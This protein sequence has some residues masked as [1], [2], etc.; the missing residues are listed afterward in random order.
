MRRP[1]ALALAGLA[2]LSVLLLAGCP[3]SRPDVPEATVRKEAGRD[4]IRQ[5]EAL[6]GA[7]VTAVIQSSLVG[8][9]NNIGAEAELPA[10][11]STAQLN[12]VGDSIERTIWLSDLDPLGRININ[13]TREGSSVRV[14]QRLY[15]DPIDT[16]PLRAKFGPRPIGLRG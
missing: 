8:G 12:A 9:Q 14:L 16:R 6:P 1:G 7:T 10:A 2:V 15:I 4:L 3:I 11:A 13:F 5:L